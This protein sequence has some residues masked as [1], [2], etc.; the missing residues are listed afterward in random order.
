MPVFIKNGVKSLSVGAGERGLIKN[1]CT[2]CVKIAGIK[3]RYEALVTLTDNAGIR[4]L[5]RQF[6]GKDADTDVLS[7]PLI[8]SRHGKMKEPGED[9]VNPETGRVMLG[10]I[11]ISIEKAAEQALTYGHGFRRELGFLAAHGMFHLLG[12]DHETD[13]QEKTMMNLQER[14]LLMAGLPR[15]A[16]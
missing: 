6:R 7:F 12:Y 8:E 9:D 13:A 5:N 14:A 16:D 1:V 11:V 4:E 2:C 15:E 3:F 10:D